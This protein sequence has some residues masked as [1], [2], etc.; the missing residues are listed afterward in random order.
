MCGT[1]CTSALWLS[2]GSSLC[3]FVSVRE[4]LGAGGKGGGKG[5]KEGGGKGR[6][7][8]EGRGGRREGREWR[9]EGGA[10][11]ARDHRRRSCAS[12]EILL[13]VY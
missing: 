7:G 2:S 1:G 6:G 4:W 5:G 10:G 3:P 9:E 11:I 13:S 8:R 12:A